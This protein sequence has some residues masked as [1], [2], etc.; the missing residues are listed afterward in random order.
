VIL[1]LYQRGI[2]LAICSKNNPEDAL[3]VLHEHPAMLLRPEHFAAL[4]INWH[5][6]VR[7]LREIAEELNIGTDALAFLDDNPAE[8]ER[9]QMEMPEV[10]VIQMPSN[11]M[12]YASA[13]QRCP[14]F[15]RLAL[16]TEDRDRGQYYAGE[17]QRK[18]LQQSAR[19][20]EDFYKS[21]HM[22]VEI[23]EVNAA[24]LARVAQLTRKT[25][26]FNL[27]TRRYTE[28]QMSALAQDPHWR[29]YSL[30]VRDRFGD[31][32]LVGVAMAERKEDV[33]EID[34]FL[35][36]C[37][38]IG[39]TIETALLARLAEVARK[40]GARTLRGRFVPTPKNLPAK[41]FLPT[42]GF[43]LVAETEGTT[44]WEFDLTSKSISCPEWI[45]W[46]TIDLVGV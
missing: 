16:S 13:L 33:V 35:L 6:K 1:D 24:T 10:H 2:I 23:A 39:R 44:S 18:D 8:R 7:N 29:V 37:R 34:N 32:G 5:D 26:Q 21:L 42:H 25:N 43:K 4:R 40:E 38:V 22:E 46:T 41:D 12:D 15:E 11:P 20:L 19:S 17:R 14:F 31:N 9:V 27:T 28:Q 30:R 36:S 3:G 45:E